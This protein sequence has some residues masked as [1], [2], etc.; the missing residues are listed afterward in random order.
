MGHVSLRNM[1]ALVAGFVNRARRSINISTTK[2]VSKTSLV[3]PIHA[4][5]KIVI[6]IIKN[7]T[8]TERPI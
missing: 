2:V 7:D 6:L 5:S 3:Y 1:R 4:I 8:T